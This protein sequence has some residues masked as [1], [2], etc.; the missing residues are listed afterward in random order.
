MVQLDT[1]SLQE[2]IGRVAANWFAHVERLL[3]PEH[4]LIYKDALRR[5]RVSAEELS[6]GRDITFDEL[7]TA[8]RSIRQQVPDITLRM[9][10]S[11]NPLD[12][13][14]LGYA[15]LSSSSVGTALKLEHQYHELTTDRFYQDLSI[16]GDMAIVKPIPRLR[17]VEELTD[18]AEDSI[19]GTWRLLRDL[20][21]PGAAGEFGLASVHF[22]YPEPEYGDTYREV[23]ACSIEF[24]AADTSLCFPAAWLE[25]PVESANDVTADVCTAM[26]ERLLGPGGSSMDTTRT[27]RR[28]LLSRPGRHMLHLEEAAEFLHLSPN[29]LRKRL[30]RAGTSYKK[31]VLDVRMALARHYLE[32]TLMSVSDIAYLLDYSQPAPFIR[33][34]RK[35][36]GMT[37]VQCRKA[38]SLSVGSG[39]HR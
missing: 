6:A 34:F 5:A 1:L 24:N 33:A 39:R 4:A 9:I 17:F 36:T 23:F 3:T 16:V 20:L 27:V 21:G 2:E 7:D 18:I 31:L 10:D 12:L 14:V 25:R 11:L 35:Y 8:L 26:C 37:P 38:A 15:M 30:Y 29:Q 28:L 32:A 19:G 22:A 13:G